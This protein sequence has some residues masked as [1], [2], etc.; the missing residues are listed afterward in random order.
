MEKDPP[1]KMR[2]GAVYEWVVLKADDDV[3]A[4]IAACCNDPAHKCVVASFN[5]GGF[6]C[7]FDPRIDSADGWIGLNRF[8]TMPNE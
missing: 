2:L 1:G 6:V 5:H 4:C 7:F 8:R 3:S